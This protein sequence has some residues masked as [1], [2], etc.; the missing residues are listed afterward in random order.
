MALASNRPREHTHVGTGNSQP[1]SPTDG[2]FPH[3]FPLDR[4]LT[5]LVNQA[6]WVTVG[7]STSQNRLHTFKSKI[8][9]WIRILYEQFKT[10][11]WKY[12]YRL[13]NM[14][15]PQVAMGFNTNMD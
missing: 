7:T 13:L 6:L 9:H 12:N 15:D 3:L 5:D 1:E 14:E 10:V 2:G 8:K 11:F 4:K